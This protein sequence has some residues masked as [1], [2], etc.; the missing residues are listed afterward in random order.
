MR[1]SASNIFIQV[2]LIQFA[3]TGKG[4]LCSL[5]P[6]FGRNMN[7]NDQIITLLNQNGISKVL[8]Q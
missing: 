8:L 4:N 6:L 1:L 7:I 2:R 5:R 3:I